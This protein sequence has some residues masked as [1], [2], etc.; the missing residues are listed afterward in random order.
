MKSVRGSRVFTA[1]AAIILYYNELRGT[2]PK[3]RRVCRLLPQLCAWKFGKMRCLCGWT[4]TDKLK[5]TTNDK[6]KREVLGNTGKY[7]ILFKEAE[8]LPAGVGTF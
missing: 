3:R 1:N 8:Y 6:R 7:V 2:A 5:K 4:R